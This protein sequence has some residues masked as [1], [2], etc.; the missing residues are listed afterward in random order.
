VH[1]G[2]A[3][4]SVGAEVTFDTDVADADEIRR[5]LL[6]V[7]N[8]TAVRLR[9]AGRAGRTVTVKV[10]FADLR[11]V[12]RSRTLGEPT[13]VGK[14]IFDVAWALY[15]AL[16]ARQ[17]IRL[18]GVRVDGLSGAAAATPRQLSLDERDQLW[19]DAEVAADAAV[20]RFGSGVVR[21]ASLIGRP[22]A[23]AAGPPSP[24]D[25][26]RRADP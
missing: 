7:A 16:P 1:P 3:E 20:A 14:E 25:Y 21:P 24:V 18:V 26:R 12:N 19:R 15:T 22:P 5:A 6:G 10:R 4:K 11:T 8:R 23:P 13:D 9:R 2:V 17:R